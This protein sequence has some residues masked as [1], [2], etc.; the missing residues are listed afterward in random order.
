MEIAINETC[1][2]RRE[3]RARFAGPGKFACHRRRLF[4]SG[5]K[6]TLTSYQTPSIRLFLKRPV[7]VCCFFF[8]FYRT[9]F[10]EGLVL[11]KVITELCF[12][13]NWQTLI[14]S[15]LWSL[16]VFC[17]HKLQTARGGK[18]KA[19]KNA[20]VLVC[21]CACRQRVGERVYFRLQQPHSPI[22]NGD[23]GCK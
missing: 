23:V 8:Q 6:I 7:L 15:F 14:L 11:I 19:N 13:Y 3:S 22:Q 4:W 1:S 16:K 5:D 21:V 17:I 2:E 10:F 18:K 9:N 12:V 20:I